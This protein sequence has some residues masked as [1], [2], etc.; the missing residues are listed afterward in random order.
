MPGSPG[1]GGAGCNKHHVAVTAASRLWVATHPFHHDARGWPARACCNRGM[2]SV[3]PASVASLLVIGY[4]RP[5]LPLANPG[6]QACPNKRTQA[7]RLAPRE[8]RRPGLD[9]EDPGT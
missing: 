5:G 4:R 8:P 9:L 2:A 1:T 7:A 6:I 3:W